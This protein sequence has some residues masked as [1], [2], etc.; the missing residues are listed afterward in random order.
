MFIDYTSVDLIAGHGGKGAVH[1]RREKFIPKG[2][3]DGGDG[4]RGGHVYLMAD[5]NLHTLQD[6][7]YKRQYKAE[8]GH[9]GRSSNKTGKSGKDVTILVPAGT[10]VRSKGSKKIIVDL[11]EEGQNFIICHGGLGG[12]G[13]ARRRTRRDYTNPEEVQKRPHI[14]RT[15]GSSRSFLFSGQNVR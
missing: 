6:I 14:R 4:G 12:R 11:K 13:N 15:T 7:R 8:N 5:T 3:P 2:G 10:V 1:F 9:S